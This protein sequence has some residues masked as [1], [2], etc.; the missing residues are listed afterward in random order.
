MY[1]YLKFGLP[2]VFPPNS[3]SQRSHKPGPGPGRGKVNRGFRGSGP[4][5]VGSSGY[6]SSDNET[7]ARIS[8]PAPPN[9]MRKFRSESDFRMLGMHT[10]RPSSRSQHNG[11]PAAALRQANSRASIAGT[12]LHHYA[13]H[14]HNN[15]N[16]GR[17]ANGHPRSHSEADL[18]AAE[19]NYDYDP[20]GYDTR[21][22][23]DPF[24]PHSARRQSI[25]NLIYPNIQVHCLDVSVAIRG[26]SLQ[27][28]A[29]DLFAVMATSTAEG[30]SLMETL[31]GVRER[32]AGEILVNGQHVSK[33]ILRSLCGYVP[34]AEMAALDPR[35]SVQSTLSFHAALRGPMDKSDIKERVSFRNN[36]KWLS[37]FFS[38]LFYRS[39]F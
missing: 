16:N 1:T 2:R 22:S 3:G 8:R 30:T 24:M 15:N 13:S 27:A 20:R 26:I 29:G 5:T 14:N 33:N 37:I 23:R 34:A 25:H 7:T 19:M 21:S 35:M 17:F 6:D 38:C 4:P 9:K 36:C 32:M 28:K 18:L 39:T 10:S 11:I 31:A 12:T